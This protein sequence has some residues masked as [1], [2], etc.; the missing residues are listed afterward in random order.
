MRT[1]LAE[2]VGLT[3][4]NYNACNYNDGPPRQH[5]LCEQGTCDVLTMGSA[6]DA[7]KQP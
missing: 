4:I 5:T 1:V 6:R 7:E 3:E 2:I